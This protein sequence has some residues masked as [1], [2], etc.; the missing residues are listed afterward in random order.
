VQSLQPS[1]PQQNGASDAVDGTGADV[2]RSMRL[3]T[4]DSLLNS[5]A[6]NVTVGGLLRL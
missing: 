4:M 1:K 3:R 2:N 6:T 5:M